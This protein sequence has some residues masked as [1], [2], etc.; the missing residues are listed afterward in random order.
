[1]EPRFV[2]GAQLPEVL[3]K[4][5]GCRPG[6]HAAEL[7]CEATQEVLVRLVSSGASSTDILGCLSFGLLPGRRPEPGLGCVNDLSGSEENPISRYDHLDRVSLVKLRL[8]PNVGWNC[9]LP[10]VP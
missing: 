5:I 1:I 7:L 8:P 9:D 2:L 4:A 6:R 10:S 3:L